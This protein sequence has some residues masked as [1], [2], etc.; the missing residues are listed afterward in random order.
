MANEQE[1]LAEFN[2]LKNEKKL[3]ITLRGKQYWVIESDILLDEIK[4]LHYARKRVDAKEKL[5]E[6]RSGIVVDEDEAGNIIQWDPGTVLTYSVVK[7]SF[8]DDEYVTI[9]EAMNEATNDWEGICGVQFEHLAEYDTNTSTDPIHPIFQVVRNKEVSN[10]IAVAFF[11]RDPVEERQI[12]IFNS[13]FDPGDFPPAGILRHELG[14]V[15]GFR[16]EHIRSDAPAS[17]QGED[18][19]Q[20]VNVTVYDPYSVMHYL[21]GGYGNEELEF[22]DFDKKG[23]EMIYGPPL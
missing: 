13:F 5:I 20:T 7:S 6:E 23:A 16:H 10:Y 2:R 8:G 22:T 21:C 9:V 17:C 4:L 3:K 12:V 14:H 18:S 15:L 1:V 19:S 11:P